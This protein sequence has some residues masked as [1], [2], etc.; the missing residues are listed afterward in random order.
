MGDLIPCLSY[1]HLMVRS[2]VTVQGERQVS[3]TGVETLS[4]LPVGLCLEAR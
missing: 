1:I 2:Q 4:P 3:P